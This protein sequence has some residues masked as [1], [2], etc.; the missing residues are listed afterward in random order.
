VV[1]AVE[2]NGDLRPSK[3]LSGGGFDRHDLTGCEL[4]FPLGHI[5]PRATK[6]IVDLFMGI[7][8]VTLWIL[9]LLLLIDQLGRLKNLIYKT[10]ESVTI[11]AL[12]L[13]LGGEKCKCDPGSL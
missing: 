7:R 8:E 2:S 4:L 5:Q 11:S 13:S 3:V 9:G 6:K 1:T 10:L 12:M